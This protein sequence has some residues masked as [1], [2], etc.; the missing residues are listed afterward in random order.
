M[1]EI[2]RYCKVTVCEEK[3]FDLF[4]QCCILQ[5]VSICEIREDRLLDLAEMRAIASLFPHKRKN[6]HIT[7]CLFCQEK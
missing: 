7:K 6:F 5:V 1:R 3:F 2:I 4:A